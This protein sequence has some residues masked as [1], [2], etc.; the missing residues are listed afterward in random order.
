MEQPPATQLQLN[1]PPAPARRRRGMLRDVVETIL[2]VFI[3]YFGFRA[4]ALPY[5]VDGASMTPYLH[6]GERVFVS[7]VSYAH[8]DTDDL[9]NLLPWEDRDSADDIYLFDP[10]ARGDIIVLHPPYDSDEPYIKRVI[11]LPGETVSFQEG[12]V[13]IDGVALNED[14]IDGA[15]TFCRR[16]AWCEVT[17]PANS[18]FVLGDNRQ[19]STDSRVFGPIA[20]DEII[21]KAVF[22]NWPVSK[23]GPIDSP[24]YGA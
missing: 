15:I 8:L 10:P 14:Y 24:E 3:V 19:D 21:G 5:Q 6:E 17:V 7:R 12:V 22:A 18:V 9:W 20:Y 13:L 1:P 2:I 4:I 16:A 23:I 11:G